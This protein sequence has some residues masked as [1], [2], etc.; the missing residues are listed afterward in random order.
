MPNTTRHQPRRGVLFVISGPSGVGKTSLCRRLVADLP[1]VTQSVSYTTRVPRL[2]E[3]HGREYHFISQPAF[4]QRIAAGEFLEWAQVHGRL[5]GTSRQQVEALT[6]A[7]T[8]VLLAID[9]QGAAQLR[10]SEV[11]AVFIFLLPPSWEALSARLQQRGSESPQVQ[12][13][14]LMVAR[15]ELAHYTEYDY[16][17]VNDQLPTAVEVLKALIMAERH[18]VTRVG[19]AAVEALFAHYPASKAQ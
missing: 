12:E 13:E 14:R 7:G 9:I 6:C 10:T 5:Y 16:V 11:D 3:R 15:E 2:A 19:T 17:M 4:E 8:D 1:D 18:R